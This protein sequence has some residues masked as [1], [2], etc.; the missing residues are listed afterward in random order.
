M[1][2]EERGASGTETEVQL[3]IQ[4]QIK[5]EL[6]LWGVLKMGRPSLEQKAWAMIPPALVSSGMGGT[7]RRRGLREVAL[8]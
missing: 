5:P 6:I 1:A 8:S 4:S 2:R 3:L 7:L